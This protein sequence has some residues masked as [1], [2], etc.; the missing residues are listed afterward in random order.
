MKNVR[1]KIGITLIELLVAMGL[2]SSASLMAVEIF[3]N[4]TRIQGRIQLENAIYEDARFMMERIS[5]AIRNNTID[6][7]EYYNR[8]LGNEIG[9][10]YGCY[11]AQFYDPGITPVSTSSTKVIDGLGALCTTGV[12]YTGS[13]CMLFRP[14]VDKN[15]GMYPYKNKTTDSSD[16]KSN[17]FCPLISTTFLSH[18]DFWE[19][20]MTCD[21][22]ERQY[23]MD[24][25]FLI[26][27]DGTEKT[28]F[29]RKISNNNVHSLSLLILKGEDE[30]TDGITEKWADCSTNAFCCREGFMCDPGSP[31]SFNEIID[32]LDGADPNPLYAGFVPI[33][34]LRTDVKSLRFDVKPIEDPRK[35]FAEINQGIIEQPSVTITLTVVPTAEQMG[36]YI[37]PTNAPELTLQTT[38]SSRVQNN[39]NSYLGSDTSS[40]CF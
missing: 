10:T 29:A 25:L 12:A 32:T 20:D 22:D 3:I 21:G 11:A 4:I 38:V 2:F 37:N 17:A 33:S 36:R 14:S 13:G 7:E 24:K 1:R 26:S 18:P 23:S 35:A 34:P 27:K 31:A 9:A 40:D 5:R 30:N 6:Y 8:A 28:I 19:S 39:V 16:L 15:T